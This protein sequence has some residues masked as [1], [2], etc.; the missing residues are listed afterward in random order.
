ML[1]ERDLRLYAVLFCMGIG[2]G[3]EELTLLQQ[4]LRGPLID[5]HRTQRRHEISAGV[6]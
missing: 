5:F 2:P 4:F 6:D 3:R 1:Q